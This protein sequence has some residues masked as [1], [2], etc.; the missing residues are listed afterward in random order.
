[1]PYKVTQVP[2]KVFRFQVVT[3]CPIMQQ[4]MKDPVKNKICKH[5]YKKETIMQMLKNRRAQK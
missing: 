5:D 2:N 3:K 1:M 4:K